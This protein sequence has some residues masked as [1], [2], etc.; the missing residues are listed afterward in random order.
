MPFSARITAFPLTNKVHVLNLRFGVQVQLANMQPVVPENDAADSRAYVPHSSDAASVRAAA[1]HVI[2]THGNM[3]SQS[4]AGAAQAA[5][6][7]ADMPSYRW[8]LAVL[9]HVKLAFSAT[10]IAVTPRKI[11]QICR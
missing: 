1:R 6:W 10:P 3:A 7:K 11:S 8:H 5:F 4:L 2:A 9:A